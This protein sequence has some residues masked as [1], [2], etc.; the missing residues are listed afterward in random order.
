[1]QRNN[2]GGRWQIWASALFVGLVALLGAY[3]LIRYALGIFLPF[4]IAWGVGMIVH[5]TATQISR[6]LHLP[7]GLC[8]AVLMLILLLLITAL[9]VVA[10]DTLLSEIRHLLSRLES[11][12]AGWGEQL[13][14]WIEEMRAI[15]SRI[16]WLNRLR[17]V[18]GL[19]PILDHVDE[20]VNDMIRSTLGELSRKIPEWVGHLVRGVPSFLIFLVVTLIA[21]FY[22]SADLE[23]VHQA[24]L[25]LLPPR[26][27]EKLPT[28]KKRLGAFLKQ[29]ARAYLLILA[30]TFLELYIGLSI[31]GVDYSFLIAALTALVDILPIFGVGIVLIPWAVVLLIGRQFYVGFGLLILYAVITVVRQIVEPRV[32]S[33]SLGL[34]PLLTLICM[35]VG[36]R[37]FGILGMMLAPAAAIVLA[38]RVSRQS[39]SGSGP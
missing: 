20:M 28:W 29:Y 18:D 12:G 16:P 6:R 30:I 7:R 38:G 31:L 37:V 3:L 26:V 2:D 5:P 35:Y 39:S 25:N 23:K 15:T 19:E 4:L 9:V 22:F 11:E 21:C 1:M 13:T 32:V 34:H 10:A 36:Y 8:A 24:I 14:A 33:G 17:R 27:S